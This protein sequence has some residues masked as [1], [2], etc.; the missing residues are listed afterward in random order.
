MDNQYLVELINIYVRLGDYSELTRIV[1]MICITIIVCIAIWSIKKAAELISGYST[2]VIINLHEVTSWELVT[3]LLPST[4]F[5]HIKIWVSISLRKIIVFFI[6]CLWSWI[7]KK[8]AIFECFY[9]SVHQ[10]VL[11]REH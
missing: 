5:K 6:H 4:I 8:C 11:K 10:H 2:A 9:T 1:A 3:F 7:F